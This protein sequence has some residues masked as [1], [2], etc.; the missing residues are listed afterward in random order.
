MVKRMRAD[1]PEVY[2]D[3]SASTPV[4]PRVVDAM[5]PYFSDVYGNPSSAHRQGRSSERAIESA[6]ETVAQILN[7]Q[8][9]EVVFTS[10]G[11]ESDNLALRAAPAGERGNGVDLR[12]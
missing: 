5:L 3:Y 2:L 4:D 12:V 8:P 10:G 11:S 7:C 6:R 1:A 9:G